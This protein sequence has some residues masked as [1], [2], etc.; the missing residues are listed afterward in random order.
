AHA[1]LNDPEQRVLTNRPLRVI[2]GQLEELLREFFPDPLVLL[3]Q[4]LLFVGL[5]LAGLGDDRVPLAVEILQQRVVTLLERRLFFLVLGRRV[6]LVLFGLVVA[7]RR[8]P[9]QRQ[10]EHAPSNPFHGVFSLLSSPASGRSPRRARGF[11]VESQGMIALR[12]SARKRKPNPP[13]TRGPLRRLSSAAT[14]RPA[15]RRRRSRD[16]PPR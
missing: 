2:L 13:V 10:G 3:E 9:R 6:L 5:R 11:C 7:P 12:R 8:R 16:S 1:I 4:L 15:L 14:R